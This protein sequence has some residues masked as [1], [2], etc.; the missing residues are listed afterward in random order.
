MTGIGTLK[1]ARSVGVE[2]IKSATVVARLLVGVMITLTL[3]SCARASDSRIEDAPVLT[4]ASA[5]ARS[6]EIQRQV[7]AFIPEDAIESNDL[8]PIDGSFEFALLQCAPILSEGHTKEGDDSVTVQYPG[9]FAVR[10]DSDDSSELVA[11]GVYNQV[12][13]ELAREDAEASTLDT[14]RQFAPVTTSDGYQV[15]ISLAHD[16]DTGTDLL[17]VDVWSPCFIPE[18][19]TLPPGDRI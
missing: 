15:L 19:G 18:G 17:V 9:T 1:D 6:I 8:P 5:K 7:R 4:P 16:G 11:N 2:W 13:S 10:I 14:N 3:V 12:R